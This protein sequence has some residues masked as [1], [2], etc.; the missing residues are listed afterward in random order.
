MFVILIYNDCGDVID[1]VGTF[2][3]KNQA[4]EVGSNMVYR[5]R[6]EYDIPADSGYAVY[7]VTP[8]A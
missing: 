1:V 7:L 4:N 2:D 6:K 3:S 8:H 5:D